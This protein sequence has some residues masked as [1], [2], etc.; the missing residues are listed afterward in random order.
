M[1]TGGLIVFVNP[2]IYTYIFDK[3]D[4][5]DCDTFCDAIIYGKYIREVLAKTVYQQ[6]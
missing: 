4:L 2:E 1:L 5:T 3:N 6:F